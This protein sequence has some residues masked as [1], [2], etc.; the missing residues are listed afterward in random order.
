MM[1]SASSTRFSW[2]HIQDSSCSYMSASGRHPSWLP[3][4]YQAYASS[5]KLHREH[6]PAWYGSHYGSVPYVNI[7][8][9][10][11]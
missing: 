8:Q 6:W 2:V 9:A 5:P 3:L 7:E 4:L 1:V 10:L 11:Q